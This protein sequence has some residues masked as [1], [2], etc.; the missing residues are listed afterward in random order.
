[1]PKKTE[2]PSPIRPELVEPLTEIVRHRGN[3]TAQW[4]AD[5]VAAFRNGPGGFKAGHAA[6]HQLRMAKAAAAMEAVFAEVIRAAER[7]AFIEGVSAAQAMTGFT[8]ETF[9]SVLDKEGIAL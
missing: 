4:P 6:V 8:D 5:E 9:Q 2:L 3:A 1:M 7:K